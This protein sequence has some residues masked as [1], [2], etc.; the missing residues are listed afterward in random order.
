MDGGKY[1]GI[2][3]ENLLESAKDLRLG[4]RFPFQQNK[5]H[6]HKTRA[7][8]WFKTKHIHVLEWPSLSPELNAI[9]ILWQDLKTN[10]R[11]DTPQKI[12]CCNCNT[13]WFQVLTNGG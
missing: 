11:R 10:A 2:L 7:L 1:R 13:R 6:K 4:E 5:D 3:E 12:C 8:E 9:E